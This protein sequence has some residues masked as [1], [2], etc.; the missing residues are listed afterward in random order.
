M[1]SDGSRANRD[2]EYWNVLAAANIT[3]L[4]AT[5]QDKFT[6]PNSAL[7]NTVFS[8]RQFKTAP[9]RSFDVK[10]RLIK[11]PTTYTPRE[12]SDTGIAKY[13]GFWD[14]TFVDN[15]YT[16]NPAWIFYDLITH[17][18][19]GAGTWIDSS[20]LGSGIILSTSLIEL[21]IKTPVNLLPILTI[22]PPSTFVR[23]L[24]PASFSAESFTK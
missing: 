7:V 17:E 14:G 22:S 1:Y 24:I 2:T 3:N 5:F 11:V 6:Y 10:G 20:L 15:V 4:G 8:S 13:Q 16:D 19:Y 21:S 23:L 12:Y 18:R 9:K